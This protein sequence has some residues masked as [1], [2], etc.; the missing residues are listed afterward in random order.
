MKNRTASYIL[1]IGWLIIA[2]GVLGSLILGQVCPV[3]TYNSYFTDES[4]NWTYVIIG[5]FSSIVSGIFFIGFAEIIELLQINIEKTIK[6]NEILIRFKDYVPEPSS[7][8]TDKNELPE[9]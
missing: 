1:T 7:D 2:F 4:Y 3:I 5:I 6:I 8:N 9:L